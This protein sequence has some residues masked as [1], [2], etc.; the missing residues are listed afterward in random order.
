MPPR[1][2]DPD[3]FPSVRFRAPEL[4]SLHR[5]PGVGSPAS[6]VLRSSLTSSHPSGQARLPLTRPYR[7]C[8]RQLSLLRHVGAPGRKP[9]S[10]VSRDPHRLFLRRE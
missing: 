4:P 5:V 9:G 10:L 3:I 1:F 2:S 7:L 6:A 8:A